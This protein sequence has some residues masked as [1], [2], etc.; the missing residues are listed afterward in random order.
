MIQYKYVIFLFISVFISAISQ[1]LLK[2]SALKEYNSFIREYLNFQV[3]FAYFLFFAAVLIDLL[4]LKFVP[5]SFIPVI[6]T[7]SYFFIIV[8]SRII[9]KEKI[10]LKKAIGLILILSGI[11]IYIL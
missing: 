4:C 8:L 11:I 9:F 7:S 6:E 3:I 2:Q 10:H 1:I 5:L